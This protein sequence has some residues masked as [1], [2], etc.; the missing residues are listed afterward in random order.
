MTRLAAGGRKGRMA[1]ASRRSA[2]APMAVG[3]AVEF[4]LQV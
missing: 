3:A 4:A 1:E 2:L